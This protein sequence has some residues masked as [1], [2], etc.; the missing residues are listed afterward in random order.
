MTQTHKTLG[1]VIGP[2]ALLLA[3]WSAWHEAQPPKVRY[4]FLGLLLVVTGLVIQNADLRARMVFV[5]GAGVKAAVPLMI[6]GDEHEPNPA[7]HPEHHH[8]YDE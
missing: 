5:E 4:A 8:H 2:L 3:G 6:E 7:K 1:V